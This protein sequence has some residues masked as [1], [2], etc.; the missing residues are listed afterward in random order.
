MITRSASKTSVVLVKANV[1]KI[2]TLKIYKV[3]LKFI[4]ILV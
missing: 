3:C 4:Y 1:Q 2:L